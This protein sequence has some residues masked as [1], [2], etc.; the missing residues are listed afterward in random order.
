MQSLLIALQEHLPDV[1]YAHLTPGLARCLS[2]RFDAGPAKP[3]LKMA[4]RD[5]SRVAAI[6]TGDVAALHAG[7]LESVKA[8][9]RDAYPDNWFDPRMLDTGGYCG[10]RDSDRWIAIAGVHVLS[11]DY[12]VAALGNITTSPAARRRG[13]GTRVTA[14]LCQKLL[15]EGI[16]TIGLNVM[17]DNPAALECYRKLGFE[18]VAAY[19]EVELRAR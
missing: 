5:A 8:L 13:L 6:D 9:Y 15:R 3:A 16:E 2:K 17:R 7:E 14:A 11:H 1:L 4:L 10:V 19:E 12:R 18:T